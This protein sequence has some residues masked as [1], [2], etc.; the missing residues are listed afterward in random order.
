MKL[1]QP[2]PELTGEKAWLN[3]E[4]TRGQLIGEKPT[5]IHLVHQLPPV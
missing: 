4:V 5:L 1:R 2:M 3:G